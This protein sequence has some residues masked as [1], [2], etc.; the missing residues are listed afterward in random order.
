MMRVKPPI[1]RLV[2]G[3]RDAY[4][5]YLRNFLYSPATS[6]R[7]ERVESLRGASPDNLRLIL[8][9]GWVEACEGVLGLW[10]AVVEYRDRWMEFGTEEI[11]EAEL[12]GGIPVRK[13]NLLKEY[14]RR[15]EEA[16]RNGLAWESARDWLK[17]LNGP[18]A[19]ILGNALTARKN[20]NKKPA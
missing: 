1:R 18:D 6:Q 7:L 13:E 4:A 15:V 20:G 10:R 5:V 3:S 19:F 14:D 2:A 16:S 11:D 17:R 8:L 9:P 12:L